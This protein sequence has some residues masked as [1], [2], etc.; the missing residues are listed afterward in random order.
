[1]TASVMTR[2]ER[3]AADRDAVRTL[4]RRVGTW[5][6]RFD[7]QDVRAEMDAAPW[8]ALYEPG[9][10]ALRLRDLE[11]TCLTRVD[12]TFAFILA[13]RTS[14]EARGARADARAK[15]GGQ[16]GARVTH[17][18][19]LTERLHELTLAR[20]DALDDLERVALA[21]AVATLTLGG[22]PAP[23]R[24]VTTVLGTVPDL[25]LRHP[26]Q[27]TN[28]L[29]G[30]LARRAEPLLAESK[31]GA[32]RSAR[33]T[34]IEPLK[35]VWLDWVREQ[36]VMYREA[37]GAAQV[38][39][40]AGAASQV[41]IVAKLVDAATRL[42]HS[43]HWPG[44]HPVSAREI[45]TCIAVARQSGD[46]SLGV[47]PLADA[48][49]RQ[50]ATLTAA[51]QA[52]TRAQFADGSTR[53]A[54]LIRRVEHPR[55]RG[56]RYAPAAFDATRERAWVDWTVLRRETR[57][58]VLD[59]LAEDWQGA[60]VLARSAD[61]AVQ[62][63][64]RVRQVAIRAAV[65]ARLSVADALV[66]PFS[67]ISALLSQE[68]DDVTT[69]L[70][71]LA[72]G[73]PASTALEGAAR[74]VLRPSGISLPEALGA[75]RPLVTAEAMAALLP[76]TITVDLAPSV[77][78]ATARTVRRAER[79][80]EERTTRVGQGRSE[81]LPL[82]R[83]DAVQYAAEAGRLPGVVAIQMGTQLLG[84]L[85]SHIGLTRRVTAAA[86]AEDRVAAYGALVLLGDLAYLGKLLRKR[87]GDL[88]SIA[89]PLEATS[90]VELAWW[91]EPAVREEIV[92][93][94]FRDARQ[95]V[96]AAA[97]RVVE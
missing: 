93:A 92:A 3:R 45:A 22:A 36:A 35:G 64:G 52:A 60:S 72:K 30:R 67:T 8:L 58:P 94:G 65:D 57:P 48:L 51:L 74:G 76:T 34:L 90:M 82:D 50:G 25:M 15:R 85:V 83:V 44:G 41:Q 9:K 46:D 11:G 91:L 31:A 89:T 96:K 16:P 61:P 88:A 87:A 10:L 78:A 70:R 19:V 81:S 97:R 62:A 75:P 56:L 39:A 27:Q 14:R 66:A 95:A 80:R 68:L 38:T 1:M 42:H 37:L 29:L 47:V 49:A 40:A 12:G 54:P 18:Y 71:A 33:W 5:R 55:F 69:T 13:Q 24:L 20:P 4:V 7:V 43:S 28:V 21:V 77:L 6:L 26:M 73:W 23:T 86:R 63:V 79:P 84:A 17:Q 2:E 32:E 53:R 59:A